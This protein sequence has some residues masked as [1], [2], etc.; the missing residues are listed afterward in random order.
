MNLNRN[1]IIYSLQEFYELY[2]RRPIQDNTGG[3][4]SA[5]LF[6]TWFMMKQLNPE[7]IIESGVFKGQGSWVLQQACPIALMAHLDPN[8]H[9]IQWHNQRG[10]YNTTD[11]LTFNWSPD[12]VSVLADDVVVFFDDHQDCIPRLKRCQELGFKRM[13]FEDN[14]PI[15]QGD[16]I[17]P[18]KVKSGE[19]YIIDRAGQRYWHEPNQ[20]DTDWFNDNVKDYQIFPPI[21]ADPITRWGTDWKEEYVNAPE[22]LLGESEKDKFPIFFEERMDYTQIAFL[23]LK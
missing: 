8:Q 2:Q 14:Y 3:M 12:F 7:F 10:L 21:F 23:Q 22:P 1:E 19:Q 16:C 4:K 9:Q 17:S 6:G 11:F 18:E 13:I 5:H 20:Y 15:R